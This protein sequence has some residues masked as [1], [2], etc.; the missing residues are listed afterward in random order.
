MNLNGPCY[1]YLWQ[2]AIRSLLDFWKIRICSFLFFIFFEK[3]LVKDYSEIY[4]TH[5]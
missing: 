2:G 5:K 1:A 3:V 4:L